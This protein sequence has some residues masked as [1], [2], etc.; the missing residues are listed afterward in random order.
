MTIVGVAAVVVLAAAC[1][2]PPAPPSGVD[3]GEHLTLAEAQ[4]RVQLEL[5]ETAA[6]IRFYQ[7]L[8]PDQ[9]VVVDFAVSEDAFLQWAAAR[10]WKLNPRI[11][12]RTIQPRLRFGDPTKITISDGYILHHVFRG[13]PNPF[14]VTFDR[15]TK[16]V[17]YWFS[18]EAPEDN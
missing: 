15:K 8:K 6:D 12:S 5:P 17:Y 4:G 2:A 14:S 7:H 1:N 13:M 18:S 9:V 3:Q 16:R 11:G 10:G